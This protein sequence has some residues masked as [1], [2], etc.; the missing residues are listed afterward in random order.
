M[1]L[2][3]LDYATPT[4][5]DT[6]GESLQGLLDG[7]LSP[8]AFTGLWK[9]IMPT[10]RQRVDLAGRR[11][12]V[13]GSASHAKRSIAPYLYIL[14]AFLVYGAFLHPLGRAVHLSLFNWDGLTLATFVGLDNYTDIINDA[15]LRAA[16]GHAPLRSFF[17]QS[18]RCASA[19]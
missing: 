18:S 15:R 17:T 3:Y 11:S 2:P 5:A 12:S 13:S 19:W 8:K 16:F 6:L 14:P 9:R 10:S 7:R 1:L 4:M